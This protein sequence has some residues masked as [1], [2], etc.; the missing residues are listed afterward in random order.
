MRRLSSDAGSPPRVRAGES[1]PQ[2]GSKSGEWVATKVIGFGVRWLRAF[3]IAARLA[4]STRSR[5][6]IARMTRAAAGAGRRPIERPA[7]CGVDVFAALAGRGRLLAIA[8]AEDLA[9]AALFFLA[10]VTPLAARAGTGLHA[11]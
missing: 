2:P 10:G 5:S 3:L 4:L 9:E 7:E 8:V 11:G 1:E 6:S